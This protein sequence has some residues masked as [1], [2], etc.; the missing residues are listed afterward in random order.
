M[1]SMTVKLGDD[2]RQGP[3]RE[4][5]VSYTTSGSTIGSGP[6]M[7]GPGEPPDFEIQI[8]SI[9]PD[10]NQATGDVGVFTDLAIQQEMDLIE[11]YLYDNH[12]DDDGGDLD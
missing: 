1:H 5:E 11:Q 4:Y 10:P 7:N 2:E 3:M 6:D 9:T 8:E 12:E